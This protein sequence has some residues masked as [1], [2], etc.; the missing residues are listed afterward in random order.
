MGRAR[1]HRALTALLAAVV[2]GL[3]VVPAG[4]TAV[5]DRDGG[6]A[7][8]DAGE[9]LRR[10]TDEHAGRTHAHPPGTF[11]NSIVGAGHT[12]A[13]QD[14]PLAGNPSLP[15]GFADVKVI[16][17]I[18]EA[19]SVDFAPNGT[20]FVALK[21]GVIKSFDYNGATGQFEGNASSTD[22]ANLTQQV[23][24]YH[25]RGLTGI[26]V[27]PQFPTRPYI[28]VNY[29]YNRDPR[30][31]PPV[32]PRWGPPGQAYDTCPQ[33]ADPGDTSIT[34]CVGMDRV[35]R[36]T[37][38]QG[39]NGWVMAP[40][41][42]VELLA[43]GCYQFGSHASGDV[44]FGP[45]GKLYASSGEGASF[46]TL[47]YG[48]YAN[49]C[50][51]P[52]NE[53]G[54]LR[55]QDYRSSSDPLGVDG[56]VVRMNPDTG[57]TPTQANATSW[58]VAFGQRN[59][60]R[61]TFRPK[62]D[63]S[64]LSNELWSAD[65]GAS[66]A[67]E[68]NRVPDVT[69]VNAPINRGWPC[70]EG[71]YVASAVQPGWDALNLPLCE[72]LYAAGTGAVEKP[73]FSYQTRDGG[74]LVSGEDCFNETSSV[75]GIAF[76][77]AQSNYPAAFKGAMFFS[78]YARSCIWVLGKKAD[79]EPD[80]SSIQTFVQAAETPV[81]LLTGPG[82]DL[83]YVDYGLNDEFAVGEG[84]AG[85]H[86]IVYTGSNAAPTARIT[87]TQALSGPAP[88]QVDFS[89]ATSTD[90]DGDALTYV[91]DLDGNGSF[92]TSGV[93]PSKTYALG[94]YTVSLKVDDGHG[95][96][97]TTSVQ[98]QSGN[99]APSLGTVTPSAAL[100]WTAGDTINVSATATDP[101]QGSMPA[102]AFSWQVSIRHCPSGVCHTH[103]FTALTGV[104]S[105]SFVAPP[106]EYPSHL[107]LTVTVTDSGGLTDTRTVQL[108]PKTVSL[109]F[110]SA[111]VGATVTVGETDHVGPY[112]ETFIQGAAFTMTAAPTTG[113]GATI[114]A[115]GGWSDGGARSHTVTPP[116]TP[117]TYTAT[118]TRPTAALSANPISGSAPLPV[119]YTASATNAA[120][121]SGSFTYAWDLDND[122]AYD[123]GTGT[124]KSV[125]YNATGSPV[126]KVLATDSR[127]A[128]DATSV[129]VTV[130][131]ANLNP[132]PAISANPTSGPAPLGVTLSAAGSADPDNDPLTYAWDTDADGQFDDGTAVT[133]SATYS[134]V[135]PHTATVKVS[136]NRGGSATKSTTVTVTNSGPVAQIATNPAGGTGPAPLTVTFDASGSSDPDG[137]ALTYAW[138]LDGDLAYDDGTGVTAVANY[139]VGATTVALKVTDAGGTSATVTT[140][141]MAT[142][143][144]PTV[145]RITTYPGGGYYV[146]QTLGFDAA[147][148]DPQQLL[149]D[150][151]YSFVMQRQ[152]CATCPRVEVQR[153]GHTS[154]AQFQ[155][156]PLPADGHLYLV[157][158]V[159]DDQ[160]ATGSRELRLDPQ[161]VTLVVA[162]KPGK[163]HVT[164]PGRLV[165]GSTV[166]VTAPRKQVRKGVRWVFVRW[167]DGGARKHDVTV[168]DETGTLTAIYRR[169]R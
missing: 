166:S 90:P 32:V 144:A 66:K 138:D 47:D 113:T 35:T 51:D 76:G 167:S 18:T 78:D 155:V 124:T 49:P 16:G 41:S 46:D 119:T 8:A 147:G 26:A 37:A 150:S 118:Y 92:E 5:A 165:A 111:P 11:Q 21:T 14:G 126:V 45:D 160:G 88:W 73:Y 81:D 40:G 115:F 99:S 146:G 148:T 130:G 61:L 75:S 161:L 133:V 19:T 107:L 44:A 94:T 36:L 149:P 13:E 121:V 52:T 43:S 80:P 98:V 4:A 129:T 151:A 83:Y 68:V 102:S 63:G 101:Q 56:S 70:Y 55:S 108:D 106:H 123:D 120:G 77:T 114:A 143:T 64:G 158:G 82:G 96:T 69:Q 86:R 74:P 34:G 159:V 135:G 100:T 153:W 131:A 27:D 42:E 139:Q 156:P 38:T 140:A 1:R 152:D 10:S 3:L 72:S 31:N 127:G 164:G 85:V 67:E 116:A 84:E 9:A 125:T 128:T 95:H 109:S 141:V 22:F 168:W 25:D 145:G 154:S 24:N 62:A 137:G 23:H 104:S 110:A 28:Y 142:N 163:L 60:W 59:P 12:A 7:Y 58:L 48:Q 65:V 89:G 79:G 105:G 132:V 162:A 112:S 17:N 103:P 50:A 157:A 169:K 93:S 122:G 57:V 97:H 15:T 33:P 30:D 39:A 54:S 134:G 91:W 29:S 20:A 71:N 2:A 87:S 53:G 117:T 6:T 136:D